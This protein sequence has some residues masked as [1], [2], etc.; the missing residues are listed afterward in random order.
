MIKDATTLSDKK[1]MC[2][3]FLTILFC[4]L[5]SH[6]HSGSIGLCSPEI[7]SYLAHPKSKKLSSSMSCN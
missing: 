7:C 4:L 5:L 2:A 3:F 1:A 6:T